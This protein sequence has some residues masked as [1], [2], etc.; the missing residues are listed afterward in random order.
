MPIGVFDS[1]STA[2][3][4]RVEVQ[5]RLGKL[6]LNDWFFSNLNIMGNGHYLDLGCGVGKQCLPLAKQLD[7]VGKVAAFDLSEESLNCVASKAEEIGLSDI[8]ETTHGSLD[9]IG[10][11]FAGRK[12]DRIYSSYAIYYATSPNYIAEMVNKLIK[13]DG[14]AFFCGP[15]ADNN[16]ELRSLLKQ[17]D[18]SVNTDATHAA[19]FL[20]ELQTALKEQF[21]VVEISEFDNPIEYKSLDDLLKFWRSHNSFSEVLEENFVK[22]VSEIFDRDGV[23]RNFKR[24]VGIRCQDPK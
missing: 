19:K 11:V 1:D 9:D 18:P 12:F 23:F 20:V 4:N 21:N 3:R 13:A 5:E 10:K 24:A 16:L 7:A 17:L 15:R 2:L 6:D 14:S 22:I 8:I